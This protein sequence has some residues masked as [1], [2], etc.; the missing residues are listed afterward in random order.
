MKDILE[1]VKRGMG[2]P[3]LVKLAQLK[4]VL[5]EKLEVLK[6]LDNEILNLLE[7]EAD[8]THEIEQSDT[9]SQRAY[10]ILVRIDQKHREASPKVTPSTATP[11]DLEGRV[12]SCPTHIRL[13][14]L[15]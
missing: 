14:C 6:Q 3:D 5:M 15:N 12:T 7:S 4:M 8:I 1:T 2:E 11:L 9:F 10:M 13:G